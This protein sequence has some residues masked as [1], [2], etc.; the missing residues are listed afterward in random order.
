MAH[1]HKRFLNRI[2]NA[3][4]ATLGLA[5]P[6]ALAADQPDNVYST[7]GV[8]NPPTDSPCADPSCAYVRTPGQPTDP[9]YPAYWSSHWNMYRVFNGYVENP[10]P[11]DGAP[12]PTLKPGA[13][14]E[15]SHGAAYYDSKN[16][17]ELADVTTSAASKPATDVL[18]R[19]SLAGSSGPTSPKRAPR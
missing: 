19:A 15:I 18:S 11:Y 8:H 6:C 5:A 12:P 2:A 3:L 17:S 13:D 10:P 4:V 7:Y 16:I 14:Y 9:Q 1:R